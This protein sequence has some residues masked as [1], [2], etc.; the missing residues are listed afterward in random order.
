MFEPAAL[1]SML[2]FLS[3]ENVVPSEEFADAADTLRVLLERLFSICGAIGAAPP[4]PN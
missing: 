3:E 1:S 4:Y 2:A